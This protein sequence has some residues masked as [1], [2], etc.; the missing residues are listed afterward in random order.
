[1]VNLKISAKNGENAKQILSLQVY[2]Y[3]L[4]TRGENNNNVPPAP[5]VKLGN[6]DNQDS[7]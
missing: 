6:T 7:L 2:L 4:K 5:A 1:M 3:L